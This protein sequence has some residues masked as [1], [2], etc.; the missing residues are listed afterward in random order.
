[1]EALNHLI[2]VREN[3]GTKTDFSDDQ[4]GDLF[5][6]SLLGQCVY[7]LPHVTRGRGLKGRGFS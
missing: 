5:L 3:A 1:M 6:Y 2:S 7:R 4:S